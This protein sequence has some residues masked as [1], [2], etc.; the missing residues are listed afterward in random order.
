MSIFTIRIG[1]LEGNSASEATKK[2]FL[3]RIERLGP[4]SIN[5]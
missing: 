3:L 1:V 4:V 2:K 5:V